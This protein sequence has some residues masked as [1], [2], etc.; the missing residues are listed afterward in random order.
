MYKCK[1]GLK[2]WKKGRD[3]PE[4]WKGLKKITC[5]SPCGGHCEDILCNY[6][7]VPRTKRQGC[8]PEGEFEGMKL[9]VVNDTEK[10]RQIFCKDDGCGGEAMAY[11]CTVKNLGISELF[12]AQAP[13]GVPGG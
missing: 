5:I 8:R 1:Q 7:L 2:A 13:G 11:W 3:V 10:E 9:K 12:R 4:F 6:G